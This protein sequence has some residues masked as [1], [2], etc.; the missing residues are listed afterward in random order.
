M[1]NDNNGKSFIFLFFLIFLYVFYTL[2]K[3]Y[4]LDVV[5][6]DDLGL[7]Y[8]TKNIHQ[9]Y[10]EY[11]V[12]YIDS[13]TMSARPVSGFI[14]GTIIFLSKNN[15]NLYFSGL[16]FFPLSILTIFF[17]FSKILP[18]E[19]ACLITLFYT[20]SMIGTSVQ[21]SPIM[22]NSNIATILYVLSIYFIV[23][24]KKLIISSCLF[25]FS[26]FSYEIFFMGIILNVLLIKD[27]KYK[28]L[29]A[30]LTLGLIFLY[31]KFVQSYFF[32]NSYQRDSVSNVFSMQRN[33]N[34]IVWSCKMMFRD[35]FIAISKGFVNIWKISLFEWIISLAISF[36]V[37]KMLKSFD[38]NS[39]SEK[40][41]KV[42]AIAFLGFIISFGIFIFSTYMPNLFG[43]ENRNLGAIRLFFTLSVICFIVYLVR[44]SSF[45]KNIAVVGF[46]IFAF[47]LV[48]TN[49]GVKNS[50]I[51]AND[52]NN[53]IFQK[54]KLELDKNN[55]EKGIVC[56][57]FDV[58]N[59]VKDN[60]NFILREPIF[61]N[62]WEG[63]ELAFRNGINEKKIRI[64]N[65]ARDKNCDYQI[66]IKKGKVI[67]K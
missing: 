65:L 39:Y 13:S 57:D 12:S 43:F 19:I 10:F 60:P 2:Y 50:W 55:V 28:F 9:N 25:I 67:F 8:L 6:A 16:L 44:K 34:I 54:V 23:V 51:Y 30:L 26:I 38:F 35:C 42:A 20:V 29:Y 4:S 33:F 52:F 18:K 41:K 7:I 24:K 40:L 1:T 48:I 47:V 15:D 49:L 53:Q 62:G 59:E 61:F 14:T 66:F 21:F 37:F 36:G 58:Y 22:L 17:V 56:V 31:R 3:I 45:K 5:L 27:I 63:N 11:I 46:S 32:V 64:Q